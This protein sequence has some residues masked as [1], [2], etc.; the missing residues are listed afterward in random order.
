[1]A[2]TA[3]EQ[4]AAYDRLDAHGFC[5]LPTQYEIRDYDIMEEFAD[6]LTGAAR[7]KLANALRRQGIR[8]DSL[9]KMCR[10]LRFLY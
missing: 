9:M 1:M 7:E 3:L 5:R 6:T 8:E 2:M 4:Q 10:L